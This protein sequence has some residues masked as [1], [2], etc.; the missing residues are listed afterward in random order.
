MKKS[1]PKIKTQAVDS[2]AK[3]FLTD[4][5][6]KKFLDVAWKGRHSV[7]DH[8]LAL[9]A[10]RHA[11]R[12]SELIGVRLKDLDFESSRLFVRRIKGGFRLISRSRATSSRAIRA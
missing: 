1:E 2:K 6:I 5:E 8:C 9:M 3:N 7:R 12:V 4:S 10:Y 11:F